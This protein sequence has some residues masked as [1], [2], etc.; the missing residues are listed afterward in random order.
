MA[1]PQFKSYYE[2]WKLE[3]CD[4]FWYFYK[5]LNRTM[6]YGNSISRYKNEKNHNV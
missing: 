1:L 5:R 4:R 3:G 2:V 6:Q